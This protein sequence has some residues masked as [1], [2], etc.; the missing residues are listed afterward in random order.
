M[1]LERGPRALA[2]GERQRLQAARRALPATPRSAGEVKNKLGFSG[3]PGRRKEQEVKTK[4]LVCLV[5]VA[6]DI[7]AFLASWPSQLSSQQG[8]SVSIDNDDIGGM[9]T[10]ANFWPYTTTI[11]DFTRRAMS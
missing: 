2:H 3:C 5:A 9:V 11:L 6:A 4:R 8:T 10:I 7:A 1:E